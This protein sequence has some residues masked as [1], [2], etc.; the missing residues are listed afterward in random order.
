MST[1]LLCMQICGD[2]Q[3]QAR[4][5]DFHDSLQHTSKEFAELAARALS[6]FVDACGDGK[7]GQ[8]CALTP[9]G[10]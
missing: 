8:A 7:L 10:C 5:I 1:S 9:K 3:V 2:V 6:R 4:R